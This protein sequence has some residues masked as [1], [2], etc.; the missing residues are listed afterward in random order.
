MGFVCPHPP[1]C[2]AMQRTLPRTS[3]RPKPCPPPCLCPPA[4]PRPL[5]YSRRMVQALCVGSRSRPSAKQEAETATHRPR[6]YP[7]THAG[8]S[9]DVCQ[10]SA[11]CFRLP[12]C[13]RHPHQAKASLRDA[14]RLA[15]PASRHYSAPL[16]FVLPPHLP[17]CF[18]PVPPVASPE[19]TS[20]AHSLSLAIA[21]LSCSGDA[22]APP[23]LASLAARGLTST[24][25]YITKHRFA[26]FRDG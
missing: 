6:A 24:L 16:R 12:H 9:S 20:R 8:C 17:P 26:C 22:P 5:A 4:S 11:R 25:F 19:H 13:V 14:A 15:M 18:S 23:P 21:P 2:P 7:P 10:V 1:F 3:P